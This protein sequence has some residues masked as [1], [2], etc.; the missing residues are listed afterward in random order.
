MIHRPK[1]KTKNGMKSTK[2]IPATDNFYI[3]LSHH[4]SPAKA[5][6]DQIQI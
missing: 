6:F 5:I 1:G 2:V 3:F 4:G